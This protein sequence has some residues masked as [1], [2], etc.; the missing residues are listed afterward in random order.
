MSKINNILVIADPTADE[1]PAVEK[2]ARLAQAFDARLELF[3]CETKES[4]AV[5]YAAHLQKGGN[6]DFVA[7]IRAV[8]DRIAQSL[9]QRGV[10]VSVEIATGDP[11]HAKLLERTQRMSADLVVKDTHHHSIAKRTFI[12]NTDWHL[13]RGCPVPL[14]LTKP[15]PWSAAPVV[16]AAVDPGHVNDKPVALDHRILECA[17]LFRDGLRGS[18]RV[19]HS[20]LPM[21]LVAEAA[22]GLPAMMTPITPELMEEERQRKLEDV[23]RLSAPYGV[24]AEHL[25]VQLGVASDVLPRFA[26]EIAAD[27]MVMGAISRS[28]L[29]RLFIGSTAERV[30]ER[31]PCDA[32]VVKPAGFSSSLSF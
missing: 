11:L 3:A 9:R 13:I 16:A 30:L 19:L 12:T 14:L 18:M 21:V 31:L 26:G 24:G 17:S 10:D 23:R 7:H 4:H 8:L 1:Q 25:A 5:R 29:Q 20:F 2:A 15:R 27:V 22:S 32:L 28:G 6:P